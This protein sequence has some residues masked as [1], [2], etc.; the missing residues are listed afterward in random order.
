MIPM[1]TMSVILFSWWRRSRDSFN[2]MILRSSFRD[3]PAE[4]GLARTC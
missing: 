4:H 1:P 3:I 2:S